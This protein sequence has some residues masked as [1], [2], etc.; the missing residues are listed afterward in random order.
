[1]DYVYCAV[2]SMLYA[3]NTCIVLQSPRGLANNMEVIG[4]GYQAFA[5]GV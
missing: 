2:L 5:N 1:M 4:E 3:D